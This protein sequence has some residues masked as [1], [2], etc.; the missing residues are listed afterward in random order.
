MATDPD[1]LTPEESKAWEKTLK[2]M[3]AEEQKLLNLEKMSNAEIRATVNLSANMAKNMQKASEYLSE[4]QQDLT[5]S[6]KSYVAINDEFKTTLTSIKDFGQNLS[7]NEKMQRDFGSLLADE[8]QVMDDL[9]LKRGMLATG[10][11]DE[12]AQVYATFIL[13]NKGT[14]GFEEKLALLEDE[15]KKRQEVKDVLDKQLELVEGLA[16]FQL[17][18]R[19]ETEKPVSY[20]HLTLPT[21]LLV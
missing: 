7:N 4:Y 9:V 16:K 1:K 21:I 6:L 3:T 13:E 10:L 17:D 5:K 20:T 12:Y 19:E 18:V 15:L 11:R 14:E 8:S 2:N